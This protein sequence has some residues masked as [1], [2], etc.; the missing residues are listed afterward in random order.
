MESPTGCVA[1]V[2]HAAVPRITVAD[3]R[4]AGSAEDPSLARHRLE[5]RRVRVRGRP[6]GAIITLDTATARDDARRAIGG[7]EVVQGE[8]DVDVRCAPWEERSVGMH[9]LARVRLARPWIVSVEGLPPAAI[10]SDCIAR[11]RH[12]ERIAR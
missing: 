4:R 9:R 7:R 2:L 12:E 1:P 10:S 8:D 6:R 11:E 3:D 5:Q